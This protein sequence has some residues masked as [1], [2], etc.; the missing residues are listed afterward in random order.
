MDVDN[1][2]RQFLTVFANRKA[3]NLQNSTFSAHDIAILEA[4]G[5]SARYYIVFDSFYPHMAMTPKHH[6]PQVLN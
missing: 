2:A 1:H 3:R 4:T 6:I 5:L